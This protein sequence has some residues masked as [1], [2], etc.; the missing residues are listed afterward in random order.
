MNDGRI[1]LSEKQAEVWQLLDTKGI[2][3]VFAGGGAGGGKSLL[4]CLRQI[5]RRTT[6]AGTRGI[7]GRETFTSLMDSTMKT[8]FALLSQMGYVNG[9]HYKYNAQRHEIAF[10]NGSEQLFRHMKF[11]PSDP[12]YNRFGS[13]E[14]TD[15]FVDEAP[16]VDRRACQILVSRMRYNHKAH[17]IEKELLLTGNPGDHWIK[18]EFIMDENEEW[19]TLPK[20]RRRVLFTIADN[21]DEFI[22]RT[23]TETLQQLDDYDRQRLL[24]GDW[25][26]KQAVDRP[27]AHAFDEKKHIGETA[28]FPGAQ[29]YVLVDFNVDPFCATVWMAWRD[30]D[31]TPHLHG[32]AE[33]EVQAGVIAEMA[34]RIRAVVGGSIG[35][36]FL[37]G[38]AMGMNRTIGERDNK[39]MFLKLIQALKIG[40]K[41]FKGVP[42]PTHKTSREDVN[43]FLTHFPDIK[44][45]RTM[46][47]TIRDLTSVEVDEFGAIKKRNRRDVAQRADFLDTFR[48]LVNTFF[49]KAINTHRKTGVW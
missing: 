9:E 12:D 16:E 7:I 23:Y 34:D 27:F 6:Y 42:N 14:Y 43:Y 29:V 19:I 46:R 31:G 5:Y 21:P 18:N 35:G 49:K 36:M 41:Q 40:E 2:T 30:N 3:E 11:D 45:P 47:G 20:H 24:Y 48:Y 17:G 22:R 44:I 26:A 38:D 37:S 1:E 25:T 13:T 39:S 10:K 32:V 28:L 4:G 33:V 15:G 8:Y